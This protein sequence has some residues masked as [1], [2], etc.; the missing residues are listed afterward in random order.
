MIASIRSFAR[1]HLPQWVHDVVRH[2]PGMHGPPRAVHK[3]TFP[4]APA[5]RTPSPFVSF[6]PEG[7]VLERLG[8]KYAPTK[9]KNNYLRHYW[10]HCRD[11]R[12]DVRNV[13]EIGV[14]TDRSL[15][16]WEEF[17]PHATIHGIDIDPKCREFEGGRRRIHIG[18]QGDPA[19]LARVVGAAGAPFDIVID[20]GSHIVEHQL[21]T[22]EYL[23]PQLSDHG[24]YVLEDTGG[25][26]GDYNLVVVNALKTLIDETMYWPAGFEPSRWPELSHLSPD[27]G[28]GA[29]NIVGIAFYRWIVFVMRGHNPEDNP[30]LVGNP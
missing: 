10:A 19:F 15:R 25:C 12:L 24:I 26:V 23:F 5:A 29:R 9:R 22:F 14:Q 3:F 20:D 17:F 18:D 8:E 27:A 30:Y 16:M 11:I 4:D 2:V 28:W 7:N 1:Q 6:P 13:L 21:R